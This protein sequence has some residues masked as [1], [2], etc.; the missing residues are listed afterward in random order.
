MNPDDLTREM[1]DEPSC[2][3]LHEETV[4]EAEIVRLQ[5]EPCADPRTGRRIRFWRVWAP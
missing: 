1:A 2:D 3:G 4:E 5:S